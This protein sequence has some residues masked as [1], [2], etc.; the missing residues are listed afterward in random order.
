MLAQL[1]PKA[2]FAQLAQLAQL[3]RSAVQ[4]RGVPALAAIVAGYTPGRPRSAHYRAPI[5]HTL[6]LPGEGG[7]GHGMGPAG[8]WKA[9]G[10]A[11]PC[12]PACPYT[13][14][15]NTARLKGSPECCC[16]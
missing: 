14:P 13:T 7:T 10:N 3:C 15:Q 11:F 1:A 12:S 2:Q 9:P 6:A 5:T 8:V 4:L 16:S